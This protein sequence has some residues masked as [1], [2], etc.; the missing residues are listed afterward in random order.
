MFSAFA[1]S[2]VST[3]DEN[4]T[5]AALA[6]F[7]AALAMS[8]AALGATKMYGNRK[9]EGFFVLFLTAMPLGIGT[10]I[11]GGVILLLRRLRAAKRAAA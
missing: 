9:E 6:V 10:F 2:A 1:A 7:T 3:T 8:T 5:F 4:A 11:G